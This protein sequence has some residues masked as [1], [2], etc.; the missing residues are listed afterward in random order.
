MWDQC[1]WALEFFK[2]NSV[3]FWDMRCKDNLVDGGNWCLAKPGEVYVVY[4][5][6]GGTTQ[7][8]L[9]DYHL[10][11]MV[12]WFNPRTGDYLQD[13]SVETIIGPGKVSVGTPPADAD[14]D[15][16]VLIRLKRG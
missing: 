7:I 14:K 3:P 8:D 6:D 11:F 1:R 16:V 12:K 13:G 9:G 5:E 2:N 4:L 10:K 15:W